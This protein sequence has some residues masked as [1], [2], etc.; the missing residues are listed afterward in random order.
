ML[1]TIHAPED[2]SRLTKKETETLCG[3]LRAAILDATAKNG[4]H[5]ASNLGVVE[6]T[7]AVHQVFSSP[8]DT[9][10][11]DVG[12]QSY[13]HKLLTGRFSSFSTLRKAGGI[14]GFPSPAESPHDPFY[15]GHGGTGIS[16][17]LGVAVANAEAKNG[18]YTVV[19]VGDG[20]CTNGLIYEALNNCEGKP[21][22]L[23]IVLNDNEM[24]ISPSVGG[25]SKSLRRMRSSA[26]YFRFKHG[27][28]RFLRRIPLLGKPLVSAARGI[29]NG[30]KH[31]VLNKNV[32]ENF[33]L[34]YIGPVD[35]NDA[36]RVRSVLEEAKYRERCCVVHLYTK[37][38]LGYPPAE[39][40]PEK[41]HSVPP[42]DPAVGIV[43]DNAPTFSTAFG[44]ALTRLAASDGR[45]AAI[46][47]AMCEGTGLGAF[48][49]AY[50]DRFFDVGMAEEHAVSFGAGL[51]R[52]GKVPVFAV[53]STFSQRAYDE[54]MQDVAMQGL[55]FVLA[56]DRCGLVEGDGITHQGIFD[57][58]LFSGVPH[59]EI[60]SP[61][62]YSETEECLARSINGGGFSVV[63]YPKGAEG[64][65]F[66][67]ERSENLAFT[68]GVESAKTVIVTYGRIAWNALSC[69]SKEV[70]MVRMIRIFPIDFEAL[71]RLTSSAENIYLIEEGA[72]E[73][74]I[75]ARL[76]LNFTTKGKRVLVRS[77][78][79][80]VP[81]GD[82]EDLYRALGFSPE[83]LEKELSAFLSN[84]IE[85]PQNEAK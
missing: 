46:T 68:R 25:F 47:A 80:F 74:G 11:F 58:A 10:I 75:S 63:R 23:I 4:G 6:A 50:P 62:T 53:Y 64:E 1:E 54:I 21:L 19:F 60:Y 15:E 9:I 45:I 40:E 33:G 77:I 26:G 57:C 55:P 14:S 2:L 52:M 27:V 36:A 48:A 41:Y 42:F 71:D 5:L 38:G 34:E 28:K 18:A 72:F 20:T 8:D 37:K 81:H 59:A 85:T 84:G 67:W 22:R 51:A 73:G 61:A 83:A 79:D 16:E 49:A 69:L 12:H 35:G 76:A 29:K 56:L 30:V 44:Q 31:L 13:A 82:L 65:F 43:E 24:S 66:P 3:E 32:F 39:E 17:G 7:V 70:G 78:G